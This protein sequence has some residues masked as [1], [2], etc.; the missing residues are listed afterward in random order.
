MYTDGYMSLVLKMRPKLVSMHRTA[1]VEQRRLVLGELNEPFDQSRSSTQGTK[2]K[3]KDRSRL[4]V[5]CKFHETGVI[6]V[7]CKLRNAII[8]AD[9]NTLMRVLHLILNGL[10]SY[11]LTDEFRP[12]DLDPDKE[13]SPGL[14]FDFH[15]SDSCLA[16]LGAPIC[17]PEP[18]P[19]L[20]ST[21]HSVHFNFTSRCIHQIKM[22]LYQRLRAYRMK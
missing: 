13:N 18:T 8:Y 11:Q 16:L 21:P 15:L 17:G 3:R 4:G 7:Q 22:G 19:V 5:V 6:T 14:S 1:D 9:L 12:F 10:P 20:L 2:L